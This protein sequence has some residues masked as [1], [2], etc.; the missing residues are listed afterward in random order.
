MQEV[1]NKLAGTNDM[2]SP[3]KQPEPNQDFF[4]TQQDVDSIKNEQLNWATLQV[5]HETFYQYDYPVNCSKHRL[6]LFP[7]TDDNQKVLSHNISISTDCHSEIFT[8]VFDNKV[9]LL[10]IEKPFKELSVKMESIVKVAP[11]KPVIESKSYRQT[12]PLVWLPWQRQMMLS[13]LLPPDL[14]EFQLSALT[15]YALSFVERN[16][17]QI[18]DILNDINTTIYKEYMYV[19]GLTDLSTTPFELF[20]HRKGVCQDFANLFICLARLLNI[21]A[22][23]RSGY[24]YTGED[25]ENTCQSGASHAWA[26]VYLPWLGWLGYDPTNGYLASTDHVRMGCGR[27]YFDAA[28]ISGT[29][30]ASSGNREEMTINVKVEAV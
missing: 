16:D 25:H 30:F 27:N 9:C 8:D 13:Y 24:I 23:Y 5:S 14:P 22:R 7:V 21:P 11:A 20:Q 2:N 3:F 26:E 18:I 10:V 12:Y 17:H 15:E 1:T 19:S 4:I 6:R 29:V 28:P